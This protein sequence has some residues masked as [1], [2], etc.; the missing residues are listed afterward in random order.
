MSVVG[1]IITD[2][3]YKS[4]RHYNIFP[5]V[6]HLL[7][8]VGSLLVHQISQQIQRGPLFEPVGWIPIQGWAEIV[9]HN[10]KSERGSQLMWREEV[11]NNAKCSAGSL[12]WYF[13]HHDLQGE[14]DFDRIVTKTSHGVKVF[15]KIIKYVIS[16]VGDETEFVV[17]PSSHFM[18]EFSTNFIKIV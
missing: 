8:E 5:A 13:F 1:V 4:N 2:S 16:V 17:N 9:F 12:S 10:L 11:W 14:T 3:N 15:K 7:F 6:P 18:I